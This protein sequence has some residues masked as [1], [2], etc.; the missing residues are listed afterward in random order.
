MLIPGF[1]SPEVTG[2]NGARFVASA[3]LHAPV[4]TRFF[5]SYRVGTDG[6]VI[7][8]VGMVEFPIAL[9][10]MFFRTLPSRVGRLLYID[11]GHA[12]EALI[13]AFLS[14]HAAGEI[15]GHRTRLPIV[16]ETSRC[17]IP[18]SLRGSGSGGRSGATQ[19]ALRARVA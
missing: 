16:R 1:A 17:C 7:A 10:R 5:P 6:S 11:R 4:G 12:S 3:A 8:E 15:I 18:N 14:S 2:V 19:R 13:S 9:F